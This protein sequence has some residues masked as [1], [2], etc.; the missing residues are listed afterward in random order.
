VDLPRLG[1]GTVLSPVAQRLPG[2][3]KEVRHEQSLLASA[4]DLN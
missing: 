2:K 3:I 4:L 1:D